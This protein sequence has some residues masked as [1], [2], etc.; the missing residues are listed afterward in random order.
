MRTSRIKICSVGYEF[1]LHIEK[2]SQI[3]DILRNSFIGIWLKCKGN[4]KIQGRKENKYKEKHRETSVV[5]M[6]KMFSIL[7]F[8][9][10]NNFNLYVG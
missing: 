7:L 5:N 4:R 3:S 6:N 10:F 1:Y 8:F 2:E 9:F